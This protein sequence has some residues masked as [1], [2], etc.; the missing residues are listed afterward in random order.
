[1]FR[2]LLISR[3]FVLALSS[4][5]LLAG[6]SADDQGAETSVKTGS[7][8]LPLVSSAG[9]HTYRL[10]SGYINLYGPSYSYIDIT[11]DAPSVS[12]SLT[13]GHYTAY[14]NYPAL[15]RDDGTG[16]FVPVQSTLLSNYVEFDIYD[17][18]TSSISFAFQTDGALVRIGA[19]A[20]DVRVDVTEGAA[21]CT[22]FAADCGE[23]SW[24]P[25]TELSGKPRACVTAGNQAVGDP[26]S[27]PLDCVADSSCFDFGS[28][29]IC[30]ELCPAG[31]FGEACGEGITC[32]AAGSDYG[33]CTPA[34]EIAPTENSQ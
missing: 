25:P 7:L 22:P 33:I 29:P 10:Y 28:G 31:R 21:V 12:T 15:E 18:T 23:G 26:C 17:G 5:C 24:C 27:G 30:A 3:S 16:T 13:T 9:G 11:G 34:A 8:E 6:C 20:L 19:G 14:L 1:M 32:L 2:S 4:A